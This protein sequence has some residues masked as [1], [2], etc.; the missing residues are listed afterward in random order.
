MQQDSR[1]LSVA[2]DENTVPDGVLEKDSDQSVV[3][4]V[5]E[6]TELAN[7][8]RLEHGFSSFSFWH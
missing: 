8:D 2:N 7:S 5:L 4:D 1:L 3:R 6:L